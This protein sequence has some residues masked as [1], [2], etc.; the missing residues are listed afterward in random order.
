MKRTLLVV[1]D[2][3]T[4]REILKAILGDE[5][6]TLEAAD[7]QEALS[8]MSHSYDR[9]SAVLLDLGMPVLDGFG[10]LSR[11]QEDTRLKQ[12]PVVVTTVQA[13]E[14]SEGKALQLGANDYITKPYSPLIVKQRVHNVINLRETAAM[15][16]EM[17]YDHLT[18]LYSRKAFFDKTE[19]MIAE[20]PAGHYVISCLDIDSFKIINDLYGTDMGDKILC[21]VADILKDG[22]ASLDGICSRMMADDFAV[23]YPFSLMDSGQ[24]DTILKKASRP[25]DSVPPITISIGRYIIDDP[26]LPVSAMYDRA[27][28]A[29]KNV[30]G[31]YDSKGALFDESMREELLVE[32][33]IATEMK[34]ALELGQFEPWFQ[35]QY[36]H[37]TGKLIGAEALARWR[38]PERGLISP[39]SFI[40]IF[41][42]N[43][44]V[45]ELDK[46]IWEQVC[47]CLRRW[48]NEG[49]DPLPVS[50]N[51]SRYDIFRD[52]LL[53]VLGGLIAQYDIPVELL[54]LEITESAFSSGVEQIIPVVKLLVSTGF[55][56]E[57]DD[58]G[59]GYSSLNTLKDVPAQIIKL[60]MRFLESS[61]DS[62]R[63]G[64]IVESMVRMAGW[65]GMSVIAE[66][67]E[68]IE[69]A[70]FLKSIGCFYVQGYL[71]AKPMPTHEYEALARG[72]EK[73]HQ[74]MVLRTVENLDSNNFWSPDS[75]D[76]LIFNSY[77]GGACIYEHFNGQIE[78]LRVNNKYIQV[79]DSVGMTVGDALKLNWSEHLEEKSLQKM[80]AALQEATETGAEVSSELVFLSLPGHEEKVYLHAN[81]RVIATAGA[82]QLVYCTVENITPQRL[83]EQRR[84][85]TTEQLQFLENVAHELLTQQDPDAG[86]NAILHRLLSF[87]DASCGYVFEFG[88]RKEIMCISYELH[89]DDMDSGTEL[90]RR[91]PSGV[92]SYWLHAFDERDY[93][94]IEDAYASGYDALEK[95]Q[96]RKRGVKSL[97]ALPLRRDGELIGFV[98]VDEP[99]QKLGHI[100]RL[101][102]L[103]DYIVVLLTRRDLNEDITSESREKLVLMDGI[104]GGFVRMKMMPDGVTVPLYFSKGFQ[105]LLGMDK[106]E[107]K[108]LYGKDAMA[109]V[110]PDD[111][112]I[113]R[114]ALSTIINQG[115][116]NNVSYRLCNGNGDYVRVSIFGKIRRSRSGETYLNIYYADA[117]EQEEPGDAKAISLDNLPM[118]LSSVMESTT[119]LS[120]IKDASFKYVCASNAFAKLAGLDSSQDVIGKTDYDLF[121]KEIADKYRRDEETLLKARKPIVDMVE[122]IPFADGVIRHSKTSKYLL[123]GPAGNAIAIG[124]VGRDITE[125]QASMERLRTSEEQYRIAM[126]QTG[127]VICRFDIADKTLI[128]TPEAA[129]SRGL[130]QRTG[131]MPQGMLQR[132]VIS[133]ESEQVYT[134]FYNRI[135]RGEKSGKVIFQCKVIDSLRWLEVHYSTVFSNG[136]PLF[137]VLSYSDVTE[138]QEKD[139][140]YKK[141]QQSL[142]G[143]NP[144]EYTLFYCNI[145]QN[146]SQATWEGNLLHVDFDKH[147]QTFSDRT[148]E[149]AEQHILEEDSSAYI[150]LLNTDTMLANYY[151]GMR[152]KTLEYREKLP[153]GGVRWLQLTIE[154]VE[155][156][157]SSDVEAYLMYENI[158]EDKKNLQMKARAE[159][160][161]LT[162]ILNRIAFAERMNRI[163]GQR[164]HDILYALFMLDIDD[165][166][167]VN[168]SF[169]HIVGDKALKE[170]GSR[171]QSILRSGDLVGR[172][173]GD[174]FLVC[175]CDMRDMASISRK[176][177][178]LCKKLNEP[179]DCISGLSSSIGIAVCPDDGES[180]ETLYR[181]ADIALYHAKQMGKSRSAFYCDDMGTELA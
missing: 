79:L 82:R 30:Q 26:T 141:W 164:R 34:Q 96:M 165:F 170:V 146:A 136:K 16:N 40:P 107:L 63:G 6:D 179:F 1:D 151:R 76:T 109:G 20:K 105:E 50:V 49:R 38:H 132:D 162:G 94:S 19:K 42:K 150:A 137:A 95:A 88:S 9:I 121:D 51:I 36:N 47:Q 100:E 67:V 112:E 2:I 22:F 54:R 181:K 52:D 115:E 129:A 124:A 29:E 158:D 85:E 149:Y 178:Y 128:L 58:F 110:H 44:F 91:M 53:D 155:Y 180:F 28:M 11:M 14:A 99:K 48:M 147:R 72:D 175:L 62:Q 98:G 70:D 144:D 23:V 130:P 140:I 80:S 174:E 65:L 167:L 177:N 73:Q 116:V 160:D 61:D 101:S 12:I 169:G 75:L 152:N 57:I 37:A 104:P 138:R 10:V 122:E 142:T 93:V 3:Q 81:M 166:K 156:P 119:D 131:N 143:K 148:L 71:Y 111:M 8:I 17:Q 7:G 125:Q 134:D 114:D 13:E 55:T 163:L 60:D 77:L 113:V 74:M 87:F 123:Y 66:G 5:Y 90:L 33:Q 97:L 25:D 46:C 43:G 39:A 59:S 168:D 68:T 157:S 86:I 15:I 120:F 31:R 139:L 153:G 4:N 45:Y 92:P 117:T 27:A 84:Q 18:G 106:E 24:L 161:S 78:L 176:A 102:A 172:L 69:Q 118:L 64:N 108:D 159:T 32:Q 171:L 126:E 35:P 135:M 127:N 133:R 154:L 89:V 103:G 21:S 41:E 83:A 145:T 173:G 56:V